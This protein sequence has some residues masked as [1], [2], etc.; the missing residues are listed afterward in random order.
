MN[1]CVSSY[2]DNCVNYCVNY[3]MNYCVSSYV[4]NC[5]NY[6]VSCCVSLRCGQ[7]RD[8]IRQ[9]LG[10]QSTSHRASGYLSEAAGSRR[11]ERPAVGFFPSVL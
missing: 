9:V 6:C 5:V 2:V 4:D 1:Y 7:R 11:G 8:V 3:C 10:L